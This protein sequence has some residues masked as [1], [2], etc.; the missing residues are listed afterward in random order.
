MCPL[1]K[2]NDRNDIANY[3]PITLLNSDYKIMT[4]ALSIKLAEAAPT[5]IHK[6]QAGFVKGRKIAD[7]TMLVRMMIDYAEATE[8]NGMIIALDQEKA[9]DKIA[10]DYLWRSLEAYNIPPHF[11]NTVK[12][13]YA[14][15]ETSVV[16]NGHLSSRFRVTRGVRQGDP[17][18]RACCS[19][20]QL[21]R[22][23][24]RSG[25]PPCKALQSLGVTKD[26]LQPC[27]PMILQPS[28]QRM[29]TLQRSKLSSMIGA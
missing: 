17:L 24:H 13:L 25:T 18:S 21:N 2:K 23:Q 26:L 6:S 29:T 27:L 19:T 5:L 9:Y 14:S 20:W 10:H 8:K 11:I 12:A 7:Q 1:Y 3:R 28:C 4:K 22:L 15:A 16:V